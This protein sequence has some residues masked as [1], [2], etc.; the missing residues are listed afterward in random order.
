MRL[1]GA[2]DRLW[3]AD[4]SAT[5]LA[6]LRIVL[7]VATLVEFGP[8]FWY[9][10]SIAESS[11]TLFEP[12]GL[13]RVLEGPISVQ[14]FQVI[15]IM[16]VLANV[17]FILG[18]RFDRTGP[19]FAG[20]LI[21]LLCYRNSW[22]MIY[23]SDNLVIWHI[24][25]LGLT[26]SA[27]ALSLD[28]RKDWS[29]VHFARR[30]TGKAMVLASPALAR[31]VWHWEYG[32]P[33]KLLCAV[34]AVVYVLSGVAK[35]AGP[36]GWEWSLGEGLRNQVAYDGLRKELIDEGA[37][38]LAFWLYNNVALATVM[39]VGTLVI[40]LGAP[41]VL[42]SWRLGILWA[43]GAFAMHWGIYA[44]MGITFW[45]QLSGLAFLP[46]VVGERLVAWGTSDA[47]LLARGLAKTLAAWAAEPRRGNVAVTPA[48]AV[49][50]APHVAPHGTLP[51]PG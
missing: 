13:A 29:L 22:S 39:G 44:I 41:L 11:P 19:L 5:R 49:H 37:Q 30:L 3:F 35:V 45:Y 4:G 8:R 48:V 10:S 24:L 25:I 51:D 46:F 43:A 47:P 7:G 33:I 18:W 14:L 42:L 27:D 16:T 12:A 50:G 1:L 20:L 38:P 32:Y 21:W 17:A 36:L 6:V 9:F 26:R 15:F 2:L 34:T 28:A 23:H 31:P 40:E